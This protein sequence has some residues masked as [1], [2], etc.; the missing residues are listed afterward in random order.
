MCGMTQMCVSEKAI[1]KPR[2]KMYNKCKC[3]VG[4]PAADLKTEIT[5]NDALNA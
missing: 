1:F 3:P 5:L 2:E 4:D